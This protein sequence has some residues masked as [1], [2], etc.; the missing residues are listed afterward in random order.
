MAQEFQSEDINLLLEG[1]TMHFLWHS[2]YAFQDNDLELW[3]CMSKALK[4]PMVR[5]NK[6]LHL[7]LQNW[8]YIIAFIMC[9]THLDRELHTA[10]DLWD[11]VQKGIGSYL[12]T[13]RNK[14]KGSSRA[15]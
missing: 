5:I 15:L 1:V 12:Q 9:G 8:D 13:P 10:G 14:G 4:K 11:P 3:A 7:V 2:E 6:E